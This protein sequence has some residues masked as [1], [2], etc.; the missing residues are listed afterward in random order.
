MLRIHQENLNTPAYFDQ[1][2]STPDFHRFDRVRMEA[3][4]EKVREGDLVLDVGCGLFGWAEYLMTLRRP[5]AIAHAVDFSPYALQTLGERCPGLILAHADIRE[6]LPYASG[7][8]DMVGAGELIEHMEHPQ[9]L[10]DELA[11]ATK[12]GGW[13]VVGTVDP[14]CEDGKDLEY[15]EHLWEF[16]PAELAAFSAKHGPTQYKRVGNYDFTFCRKGF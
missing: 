11:R 16:T 10:V 14:H 1:I 5:R 8:F 6:G 15:P 2:W 9:A 4:V 7:S 13:I 12:P 3:F